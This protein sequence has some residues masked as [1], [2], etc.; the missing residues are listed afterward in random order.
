MQCSGAV[1]VLG[2][3]IGSRAEQELKGLDL[4][5]RIPRGARDVAVS[6]IVQGAAPATIPG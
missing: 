2:I 5:S 4:P 3:D 1:L 6:S